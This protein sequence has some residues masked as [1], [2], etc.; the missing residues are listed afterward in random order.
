M[1]KKMAGLVSNVVGGQRSGVISY[2]WAED[3]L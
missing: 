1:T 2:K 3:S